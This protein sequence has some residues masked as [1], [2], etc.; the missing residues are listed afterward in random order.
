MS[1]VYDS[2]GI[3]LLNE[4]RMTILGAFMR[5]TSL[6]ELPEIFYKFVQMN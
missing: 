3:F 5:V 4:Q 1:D 2:E 6:D